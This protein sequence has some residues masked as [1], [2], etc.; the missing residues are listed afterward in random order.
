MNDFSL[1]RRWCLLT[2]VLLAGLVLGGSP[3][4]ALAVVGSGVPIDTFDTPQGPLVG[5]SGAPTSI[6]GSGILG[7]ERDVTFNDDSNVNESTFNISGGILSMAFGD[8]TGGDEGFNLSWDGL[9]DSGSNDNDGLGGVD[10]T[11]GGADRVRIR[12]LRSDEA[13]F[14]S[15]L[16]FSG[17]GGG[18]FSRATFDYPVTQTPV[19]VIVPFTSFVTTSGTGADFADFADAGFVGIGVGDFSANVDQDSQTDGY[20]GPRLE[21]ALIETVPEPATMTLLALGG[22]A[23]VRRRRGQ[24]LK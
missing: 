2:T 4:Q 1:I 17:S 8:T 6:T 19:D 14:G 11:L 3:G 7:G 10:L 12:V 15:V 9:D 20:Q 18:D 13:F 23:L 16:V 24:S 22:L 5:G 21:I